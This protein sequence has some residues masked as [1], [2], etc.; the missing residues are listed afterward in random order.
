MISQTRAVLDQYAAKGGTYKELVF[1]NCGHSPHLEYPGKFV[2][3]L[4][5]HVRAA[6]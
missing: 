3:A 2:T 1:E 4:V 6:G 5:E